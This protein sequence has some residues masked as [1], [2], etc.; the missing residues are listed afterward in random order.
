MI[1]DEV[2]GILFGMAEKQRTAGTRPAPP[3]RSAQDAPREWPEWI[4][5][6]CQRL[7][8][9]PPG[10]REWAEKA[11]TFIL[12]LM[13]LSEASLADAAA[14]PDN[15][16]AMLRAMGSPEL[17]EHMQASDPL[18]R[19]FLDGL[20]ARAQLIEQNGGV[21]KTEQVAEYLGI[22]TQAVNKRRSSRQLLGLTFRRRGHV[23]PA[24]QFDQ[25]GTVAGLE[26]T[27][28]ALAEH[29]EWMQNVF[30]VTPNI[31]L[32]GRRPLELLRD[33]K[34]AEVIEA[35]RDFGQH[36]AA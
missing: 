22:S 14:A 34:I 18:A 20:D 31:R 13:D 24:W 23:F 19:A 2:S 3:R 16:H 10:K 9:E 12:Q 25:H 28:L 7:Q 8:E 1:V 21:F 5:R 29:D 15:W 27:L 6:L 33:R 11:G 30:F 36:G 17:L 4:L 26:Q 35:A 32:G